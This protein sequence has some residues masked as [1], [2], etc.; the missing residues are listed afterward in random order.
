MTGMNRELD[1]S[2]AAELREAL[3]L[4][5]GGQLA[6]ARA[7]AEAALVRSGGHGAVHA[8]LGMLRCQS[9]DLAG[10]IPHL[11]RALA[12]TPDD[13][14]ITT[15]LAAAL[16]GTG[17]FAE[18]AE[19]CSEVRS[20]R[21]PSL[22][23]WRLRGYALQQLDDHQGAARAYRRVVAAA[24]GDCETWNNLGN[25]LAASGDLAEAVTA[26]ERAAALDPASGPIQLNVA[27][28]LAQAGRLEEAVAVLR[29]FV[30]VNP[31]DSKALVELAALLRHLY[32]DEEALEVLQR[33]VAASPGDAELRVQLGEELM[34][35]LRLGDAERALHEA[36]GIAPGHP[37]AHL[38]LALLL[39]HTNREAELPDLLR[40]AEQA[41]VDETPVQFIRALLCRR[42]R[43]FEDGL[44]IVER[45]PPDFEPLRRAQLEG[46][47]RDR[48][49]DADGAFAAFAEMNRQFALDPS[50][51]ERRAAAD[52]ERLRRDA[53]LVTAEWYR[54]WSPA[55]PDAGRR[56]PVFLVGFPRSGTTLLDTMLMGH[57]DVQL[58][59]EQ[60][61]LRLT[62]ER[63]G[64]L[65]RLPELEAEEIAALRDFYFERVADLVELRPEALLVDKS[66]LHMNKAPLIHRLFPDARFILALR[67]PCDVV[68]SC[69]ITGFRLNDAMANFISLETAAEYY[70][71]SFGH[72]SNCAEVMPL[73]VHPVRYEEVVEDAERQLRPLLEFLGLEWRAEVVDHSR[74]ARARGLIS[75][76]SYAQVTEGLYRRA[77]GRWERYRA[78]LGPVLPVL[79]RWAGRLGY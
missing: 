13:L 42:E 62:E 48:L 60:P 67:H 12:A 72:W 53:A 58:L 30:A 1:P 28:T 55:A 40:A 70:D 54:R 3:G 19:L 49:G 7:R 44:A 75:T 9:G 4:A 31:Q 59:E 16:V 6:A 32:R 33:A 66:P 61:P 45:L 24:P 27:S 20:A 25:A 78:H 51:P 15:N 14:T 47:F 10:G 50:Q 22:R 35:V 79:T 36:L 5:R 21:D 2:A 23:L 38:Q 29:R 17:A 26:L 37:R 8:F 46:Q 18:A 65:E 71:L 34:A 73:A 43:R 68:L 77:A 76:A 52:R 41:G 69:F 74:T 64:G 57:P 56:P 63:L 11:R 39:E